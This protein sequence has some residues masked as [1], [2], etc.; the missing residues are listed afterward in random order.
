MP[1]GISLNIGLNSVDPNHYGGWDGKLIACEY[2]ANAMEKI[3][4]SSG[5]ETIKLLTKDA[6]VENIKKHINSAAQNLESGDLFILTYSAHGGQL[7]DTNNDE[8][9]GYD[10][11]WCLYD[12]E[13]IDD[14]LNVCLRD[15]KEGVKILT[16]SDSCHSGT[17]VKARY[18]KRTLDVDTM[19][20]NVGKSGIRYRFAPDEV[21]SQTYY[22]NKEMYDKILSDLSNKEKKV[23]ASVI[24]IS[25][26]Q[27][28]EL[29]A[30]GPFNGAFTAN[31]LQVWGNGTFTGNHK[32]FH[33]QIL[34]RMMDSDQHPYYFKEGKSNKDFEKSKPFT[35]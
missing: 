18:I 12:R 19:V 3:A 33:K 22:Q 14:E 27:D 29:S 28:Q 16:L 15:F 21:L 2:D 5:C 6:T 9:D 1:K 35:P 23:Q 10:E 31:L 17:V 7:P 25:G 30:D 34:N 11:T 4:K 8:G 13:F 32:K 26:C 20:S 24:L